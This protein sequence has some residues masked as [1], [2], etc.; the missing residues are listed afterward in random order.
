MAHFGS[1]FWPVNFGPVAFLNSTPT[2]IS[3]GAVGASP[4]TGSTEGT[5][6]LTYTVKTG[7]TGMY[8]CASC[9]HVN[10]ASDAG[11]SQTLEVNLTHNFGIADTAAALGEVGTGG[12][13]GSTVVPLDTTTINGY[14][15]Q[16]GTIRA[17]AG[18]DIV[19]AT[20]AVNGGTVATVGDF[21]LEMSILR[22]A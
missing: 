20:L 8:L 15:Y 4:V 18:T 17:E 14:L 3:L 1:R 2:A 12:M 7:Q 11:T 13:T 16:F 22:L 10:V 9:F 6:L 21:D 5:D 19:L